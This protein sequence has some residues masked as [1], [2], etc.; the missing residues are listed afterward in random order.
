MQRKVGQDMVIKK[1]TAA[2]GSFVVPPIQHKNIILSHKRE[3]PRQNV[4]QQSLSKT[5]DLYQNKQIQNLQQVSNIKKK[6]KSSIFTRLFRVFSSKQSDR[7]SNTYV[8]PS[9]PR[10]QKQS[11]VDD[12]ELQ[13]IRPTRQLLPPARGGMMWFFSAI[14][15]VV[16]IMTIFSLIARATVTITLKESEYVL[17][18]NTVFYQEPVPG[19]VGFKTAT[20]T[21]TESIIVP[22]SNRDNSGST[23]QGT[24]RLFSTG[25]NVTIPAK[26][27]LV[28]ATTNKKFITMAPVTI[29]A[30]SQKN[31]A[32]AEIS[33][34]A[35]EPGEQSNIGRD[36]FILDKFTT[37]SARSIDDI[38]GGSS[39]GKFVLTSEQL[40]TVKQ[41]LADRIKLRDSSVFL[42]KQIP[43]DFLLLN[44]LTQATNLVFSEQSV[45]GG[46]SVIATRTITGTMVR[47]D[48]LNQYLKTIIIPESEQSFMTVTDISKILITTQTSLSQPIAETV[49]VQIIGTVIARAQIDQSTLLAI[50]IDHKKK[51]AK[52]VLAN[53]SGIADASITVWP[54]W[55]SRIPN[56]ISRITFTQSFQSVP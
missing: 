20:I 17:N 16:L 8:V 13:S 54:P 55:L 33:I 44:S 22:S 46:V 27:Q 11:S 31:P 21:D 3:I 35:V 1:K 25:P 37:V 47:K 18:N 39:Q 41:Q 12:M 52:Q 34:N 40:E 42:S 23:A 7:P 2:T 9:M 49:P 29:K 15:L 36:D 26:T 6:K 10:P 51:A 53:T 48:D 43:E 24:V 19:Q 30:G 50:I 14:A 5:D 32:T 56:R 4:S 45:E 28:S 38:T